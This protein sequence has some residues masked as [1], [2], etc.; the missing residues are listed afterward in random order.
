MGAQRDNNRESVRRLGINGVLMFEGMTRVRRNTLLL[1]LVIL[2][3][4]DVNSFFWMRSQW[5]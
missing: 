5:V 4:I 3:T 2:I 1:S